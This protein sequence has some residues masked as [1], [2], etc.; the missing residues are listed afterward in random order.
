MF[1]FLIWALLPAARSHHAKRFIFSAADVF[2]CSNVLWNYF[3]E[4]FTFRTKHVR[5][6]VRSFGAILKITFDSEKYFQIEVQ[7][8][9]DNFEIQFCLLLIVSVIFG[10]VRSSRSHNVC[11]SV[12]GAQSTAL[13]LHLSISGLP[14]VCV[15]VSVSSLSF[16]R[17]TDGA[18]NTSFCFLLFIPFFPLRPCPVPPG[19]SGLS[20]PILWNLKLTRRRIN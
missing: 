16:L 1:F 19:H 15:R 20:C 6:I 3:V 13:N 9:Q 5:V 14:Q 17:R 4:L 12:C 8:P 10:S 2:K 11:Q 18:F 7:S